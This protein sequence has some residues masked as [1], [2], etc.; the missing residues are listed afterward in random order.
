VEPLV[1]EIEALVQQNRA[2]V[3]RARRHVGNLAHA[4]RTRLAVMGNALADNDTAVIGHELAEAERLVSHHL[5]RASAGSLAGSTAVDLPLVSI[6]TE[7]ARAL[8]ILFTDRGVVIE[9]TGAPLVAVRCEREDLLEMLGNLLENAC[10]WCNGHVWVNIRRQ[11]G[12]AIIAMSDDGPG[13]A[14]DRL[15][16]LP[17][18]GRRLDEAMPGSGLGLAIVADLVELYRGSL[19][20]VSPGTHG[21]LQ[22]TLRLPA[23]RDPRGPRL[24]D[25]SAP[26]AAGLRAQQAP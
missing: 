4:L 10:K 13:I 5:T 14:G 12:E 3:E 9:V 8:M 11:H 24:P 25:A 19:T 2:T 1:Q 17:D 6:T 22:A 20:L 18:R 21:G 7:I 16:H 15:G 26:S 23:A